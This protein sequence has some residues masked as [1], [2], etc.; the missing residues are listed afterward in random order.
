MGVHDMKQALNTRFSSTTNEKELISQFTSASSYAMA[1]FMKGMRD[2]TIRIENVSDMTRVYN[3]WKEVTSYAETLEGS[4]ASGALPEVSTKV[5]NIVN[6]AKSEGSSLDDSS[7]EDIQDMAAR[8]IAAQ[9]DENIQS[10]TE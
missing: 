9:N 4:S 6:D 2:G 10:F 1:S 8:L 3:M 5:K 7:D